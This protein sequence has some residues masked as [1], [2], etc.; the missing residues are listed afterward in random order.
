MELWQMDVVGEMLLEDGTEC[1]VLT[2][3]PVVTGSSG[4]TAAS[5]HTTRPFD[6]AD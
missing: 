4:R 5:S 3:R 2:E 1:K 6:G